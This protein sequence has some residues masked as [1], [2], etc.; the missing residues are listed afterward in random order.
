LLSAL[1]GRYKIMREYMPK[2]GSMGL[3]MMFRTCTVQVRAHGLPAVAR[4]GRGLHALS[5]APIAGEP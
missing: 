5:T 3:D 4:A 2:V 1:Q